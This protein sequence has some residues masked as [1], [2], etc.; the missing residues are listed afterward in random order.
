MV[1]VTAYLIVNPFYPDKKTLIFLLSSREN[2]KTGIAATEQC[3]D[4]S[5]YKDYEWTIG[6]ALPS[7]LYI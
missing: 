3:N 6:F 2:S 4:S 1:E 7:S 5:N